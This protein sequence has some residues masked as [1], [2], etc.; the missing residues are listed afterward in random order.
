M[1]YFPDELASR[2]INDSYS[3]MAFEKSVR[4]KAVFINLIKIAKHRLYVLSKV[5]K[6]NDTNK[7]LDIY[8]HLIT[9]GCLIYWLVERQQIATRIH[10]Q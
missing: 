10:S 2:I 6:T 8:N 3:I 1:T 9:K 5:K 4:Y 7:T